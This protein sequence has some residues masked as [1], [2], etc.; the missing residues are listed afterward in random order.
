MTMGCVSF[1]RK[2]GEGTKICILMWGES[3]V[4]RRLYYLIIT[5]YVK[6]KVVYLFIKICVGKKGDDSSW[7]PRLLCVLTNNW[8]DRFFSL[9][10]SRSFPPNQSI[11]RFVFEGNRAM[12]PLYYDFLFF[13]KQQH[14]KNSRFLYNMRLHAIG[15]SFFPPYFFVS[16]TFR[17]LS[18]RYF[19]FKNVFCFVFDSH[20]THLKW[21]EIELG[22]IGDMS[23]FFNTWWWQGSVFVVF[24]VLREGDACDGSFPVSHALI[25]SAVS[26]LEKRDMNN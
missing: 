6:Q 8:F 1:C 9:S 16:E 2:R 18:C 13:F 23:F 4:G 24:G 3:L 5:A 7:P 25:F 11:C 15:H 20:I 14:K 21:E 19:I 10:Q 26:R 17:Q 22:E 12:C